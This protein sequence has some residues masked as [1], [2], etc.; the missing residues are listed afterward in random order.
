MNTRHPV[1]Q[2]E[3]A[4]LQGAWTSAWYSRGGAGEGWT[5]AN[6]VYQAIV[7][8]NAS[9]YLYWIG[10]QAGNTN[11][12]MVHIGNNKVE[13]SKRLWALGQ[14][15]RFVRPGVVWVGVWGGGGSLRT[16]GFRNVDGSVAV[17]VINSG[18]AAMVGVKVGGGE[19]VE[20]AKA[21]VTDNTRDIGVLE[22]TFA[23]GVASVNVPSRSMATVV[24]YPAAKNGR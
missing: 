23:D 7:N 8:A 13:A 1:W 5:W 24:L 21:W 20:G 17:V 6:N 14:W 12:H 22:A 18:N 2:T 16:A 10:V 11:S 15:S 19:A 9:A 3:A 4:D